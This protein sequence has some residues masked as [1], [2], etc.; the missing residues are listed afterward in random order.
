MEGKTEM[1]YP[2]M[3]H[4]RS[5]LCNPRAVELFDL[6]IKK[7]TNLCIS[8]DL[9]KSTE[10]LA[11]LEEIGPLICLA[12]TH[13]DIIDDFSA[14]FVEELGRLAKKHN[15]LIF[16]DRKFADIG[17]TAAKQFSRGIFRIADWA[18]F[19]NAH[20][21]PGEGI[22]TGLESVNKISGLFLLTQMSS[23]GNLFTEPY[24]QQTILMAKKY[25]D[26]VTGFI[27]ADC[28]DNSFLLLTP[29][30]S[31]QQKGDQF[32]QAYRTPK[33]ACERG[34]DIFIVGRSILNEDPHLRYAK[35][36]EYRNAC[37]D[38]YE[39]KFNKE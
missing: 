33:M 28:P 31:L 20:S 23:S 27:G 2:V 32:G 38:C 19:I 1:D 37:W 15:F 18:N 25:K 22:I 35:A 4:R 6:M 5:Q 7:K 12:K 34:T 24:T 16:E 9:H 29:G 11:I 8:L 10:I 39:N 17:S 13:I 36:L 21:L 30:I 3:E 26:F 14:E